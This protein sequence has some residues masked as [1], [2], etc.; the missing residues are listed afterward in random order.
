MSGPSGPTD[1]TIEGLRT[2]VDEFATQLAL[3][4]VTDEL[5][6][7]LAAFCEEALKTI[8]A[9]AASDLST[10]LSKPL[11]QE[12][13][14]LVAGEIIR[15]QELLD[16]S[17]MELQQIS[18]EEA[19]RV[20]NSE[21]HLAQL[22]QD[23]ELVKD[24]IVEVRDHL[25]SIESQMLILEQNT[26]EVAAVHTVFRGFHTIKGLAGFLEFQD[27]QCVSH[28]VETLLDSVR[29]GTL[30]ITPA[31]V[32]V[33][34]SG[35]DYVREAVDC[36]EQAI[37][38]KS[39]R[40][41]VNYEQLL[42][43]ITHAM[44]GSGQAIAEIDVAPQAGAPI[45]TKL[46]KNDSADPQ[47]L[48]AKSEPKSKKASEQFSI[49]VDTGKLDHLMDMVGEMVIA[50]SL[51]HHNGTLT[52]LQDARLQRDLSQLAR[53]TN[54]VQRTTMSMRMLPIG[55]LFQR[56][57]RLARDLSRRAGKQVELT[58]EGEDTEV[59]KTIAEELSDPLMHM[60]RNALDHGI[61]LPDERLA[62]GKQPTAHIRLAA[63]HQ[64]G[65]IVV[66]IQDDG[67]GL[68]CK[69][70]IEKAKANGLIQAD[71]QLTETEIFHLIFEPGFSTADQV[72]DISGR[73][74]GMDVVRGSIQK[75]RGRI[76][77]HSE[78]GKGTTFCLRL[79]LTLAIIDGLIVVVGKHRYI[80]PLH[81]VKEMF[82]PAAEMVSTVEG[83]YEVATV[84]GRLL[85]IVRLHR[86][87]NLKPRSEELKDG[88]LV[89][90][91]CQGRQFCL[92]VDDLVGKQEVV[93]K[94]LGGT[95]KNTPG[96]AGGAILGDGRVGLI[97]DMDGVYP[98]TQHE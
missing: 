86:R 82:R 5:A 18:I 50:Q 90:S 46:E 4:G 65:Q 91:E 23:T 94:S 69:K 32:D 75:L 81:S 36:V 84:R 77:V 42:T 58:T 70:I 79:P 60:I 11:G 1:S 27:I 24:F 33:V 62:A 61:E 71:Q 93:I 68:N 22:A 12:R 52:S 74:V 64:G 37:S 78:K 30:A 57:A 9:T 7:Q 26:S 89:V 67:R 76:D 25:T 96:I 44:N 3:Q 20:G 55:Q 45:S 73:G 39:C 87:F 13:E 21:P 63:F 95:L 98:G 41:V 2:R 16:A 53:I 14:K 15:L 43:R 29:N 59:D 35:A 56:T 72:T 83:R 49:R 28:Q 80:V 51:I 47:T 6:E 48:P 92:F 10:T 40:V 17:S 34:L 31:V 88:L 19:G 8:N 66:E 54:D 38:E 97:L 85:P